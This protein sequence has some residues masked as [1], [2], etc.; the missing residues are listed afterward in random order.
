[1]RKVSYNEYGGPKVLEYSDNNE[2]PSIE[3]NEILV[4]VI[5]T[6]FNPADAMIREGMLKDVLPIAFPFTPNVDVAGKI[7]K[8][9]PDV[10]NFNVGDNVI[11]FL[12]MHENGAATDYVVTHPENLVL[13]PSNI[14]IEDSGVIPSVSLT[15]WQ[16]LFDHYHLQSNDRI[17]ITG[18]AGGVGTFAVQLA[19][20]RGAY[21]IGTASE[22]SYELL[23]DINIDEIINYKTEEVTKDRTGKLD[24]ILNLAPI[25]SEGLEQL[26]PLLKKGGTLVSTLNTVTD[27]ALDKYDV[28][29]VRMAVTMNQE[30]LDQIVNKIDNGNI[31]PIITK[32]DTLENLQMIHE[33][34]ND[35]NGKVLITVNEKSD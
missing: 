31:K 32:R 6:S 20:D 10:K 18:A 25:S 4:K 30:E 12:N 1:M 22:R 16:A 14:S 29:V 9:G 34:R 8:V 24:Y 33:N 13:A 23:Q 3:S 5:S 11:G 28:N 26:L 17:L 15:A 27:Q 2:V 19:K 21:V 7:E 35:Y